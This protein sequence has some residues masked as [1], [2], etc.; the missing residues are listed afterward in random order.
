VRLPHW[1]HRYRTVRDTGVW[2][3]RQ[4]AV[5]GQRRIDGGS[6]TGYQP[7]DDDWVETGRF[8]D[9]G[10]TLPRPTPRPRRRVARPE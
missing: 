7:R 2:T 8:R 5:C 3:Y 4:C 9:F 6:F 1:F 10:T